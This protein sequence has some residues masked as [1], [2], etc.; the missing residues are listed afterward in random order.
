MTRRASSW[1]GRPA[2][3]RREI[4]LAAAQHRFAAKGFEGT[5][6][7]ALAAE[8]GV[9]KATIYKLFKNKEGLL[10][11]ML[12]DT[13]EFLTTIVLVRMAGREAPIDRL[14]EAALDMLRFVEE[15]HDLSLVLVRDAVPWL[16]TSRAS[17]R[18][19]VERM[20]RLLAP[21]L[22][23]E[24]AAGRLLTLTDGEVLDLV[25]SMLMGATYKWLLVKPVRG[26]LVAE[27]NL[28]LRTLLP[29]AKAN[30]GGR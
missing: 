27:G 5:D 19:F 4:V 10:A 23:Q 1:L 6:L 3:E 20:T 29:G 22:A 24:R 8:T 30:V 15:N 18:T 12:A 14:R 7:Q 11:A 17:Y 13:L 2:V 9:G 26:A 25:M 28:G 21:I 16:P